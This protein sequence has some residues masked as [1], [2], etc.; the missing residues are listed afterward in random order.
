MIKNFNHQIKI[1]MT[2]MRKKI[3]IR[4]KDIDLSPYIRALLKFNFFMFDELIIIIIVLKII[5]H[6]TGEFYFWL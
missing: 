3:I 6:E 1:L 2:I 5:E 4:K